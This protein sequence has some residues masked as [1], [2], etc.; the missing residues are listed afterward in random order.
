[1]NL[2][3]NLYLT[4]S[5]GVDMHLHTMFSDGSFTPHEAM[6]YAHSIGLKAL[7]ICDHDTVDGLVQGAHAARD[8]DIE[9]IPGIELSCPW[10]EMEH[11]LLGYYMDVKETGFQQMLQ[12]CRVERIARMRVTAERLRATG[13]KIPD[14]ILQ[15]NGGMID[16]GD[17][18]WEFINQGLEKDFSS[19]YPKYFWHDKVGYVLPYSE[20]DAEPL[21]IK[22]A[23]ERIHSANGLA[24]LAHPVGF[25]V[26]EMPREQV[27]EAVEWGLDGLEVFTPRHTEEQ[28]LYLLSLV[29]EFGMVATGGTDCHGKIKDEPRMGTLRIKKSLLDDLQKRLLIK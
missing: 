18:V 15:R 28:M 4:D 3:T 19:A 12:N 8:F 22:R 17:I 9:L 1:M 23:I 26:K 16:R 10:R 20:G 2:D 13:M 24:V 21:T 29:K 27:A 6:E 25:Y 11:H 14:A 5:G 7:G